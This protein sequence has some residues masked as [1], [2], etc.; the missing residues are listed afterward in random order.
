MEPSRLPKP[1]S[2]I[3]F[4][5]DIDGVLVH[6]GT[7]LPGAKA[8]LEF[9]QRKKIP[10]IFLTNGGGATEKDHVAIHGKRLAMSNLSEHQFV[11][12]HSPF[13]DLVPSLKDKNILVLGGVGNRLREV[14]KSY[15]FNHVLTSSDICKADPKAYLFTEYTLEHHLEHGSDNIRWGPNGEIQ[16]SAIMTWSSPRDW[17]LDLQIIMDLL[18][19]EKGRLNTVSPFNG[20]VKL[21]NLGYLQDEQPAIYF[22]NPDLTFATAHPQPRAAQGSFRAA[23]E[24]LFAARTG[25][26]QLLNLT[27][28]GKPTEETYT[29]GEKTLMEWSKTI[30]GGD[31]KI[32]TVYMVGDNPASDIQ[33]ANN[34]T[35]KHGTVWKSIL[36]ETGIHVAGTKPAYE[37]N[38]IVKGVK[39]AVG[40]AL[41]D[42]KLGD[43]GHIPE[44]G[45]VLSPPL[46]SSDVL[47]GPVFSND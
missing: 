36:V 23:L 12:S 17:G 22:S 24:G 41:S 38:T 29:Y 9:L 35:S 39:E 6:G 5:F 20:D 42:S 26:A 28:V 43:L 37:P 30:D 16:V 44:E 25:G 46:S 10:F 7:P 8:T 40:W 2:K 15:G 47:G 27:T 18:L 45:E 21:P 32:G 33:G 31:G 34:F 3:A 4:A 19:S 11:Q 14:A 13:K 1:S